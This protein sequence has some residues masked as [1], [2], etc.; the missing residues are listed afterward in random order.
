[1]AVETRSTKAAT[2]D[3]PKGQLSRLSGRVV[4]YS[5]PADI[6]WF[7][8]EFRRGAFRESL[9]VTPN[10]PLLMYHDERSDPIGVATGWDD[11]TD[12]LHGRFRLDSSS[13]A[14]E[15][16]RLVAGGYLA[17][18][19]IRFVPMDTTWDFLDDKDHAIRTRARLLEVSLVSTPAYPMATVTE[20]RHADV[21]AALALDLGAPAIRSAI[22]GDA[23]QVG[24]AAQLVRLFVEEHG[25]GAGAVLAEVASGTGDSALAVNLARSAIALDDAAD[26]TRRLQVD[27]WRAELNRLRPAGAGAPRSAAP[28]R[29]RR[30]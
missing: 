3:Q 14:Q 29:R 11:R 10:V 27:R 20:V 9:K 15:A 7:T 26:G 17:F 5:Q 8:E 30:R 16:A 24:T 18:M 22:T 23:A 28:T 2:V 25:T 19:S 13:R 21:V 6:G 12:G 1:M 4:P